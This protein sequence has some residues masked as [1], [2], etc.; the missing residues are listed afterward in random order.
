MPD[1]KIAAIAGSL[2]RDSHNR[3]LLAASQELAPEGLTLDLISLDNVPL[4]NMDLESDYPVAVQEMKDRVIASDGVLFA[5]PEHNYSY[6]G[7]LKNALDWGSRPYG[8]SCWDGK[9]VILQSAAAGFMG[10]GRAQYHLRQVLGYFSMKQMYF[11]EVFVGGSHTKFDAEGKLTDEMA[12]E[13]I[14]KQLSAFRDFI[15]AGHS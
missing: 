5:V 3:W 1:L 9:P 2:R 8:K 14:R 11:P 15:L 6:S 4:Y 7:V 12:R 10:G 13:A